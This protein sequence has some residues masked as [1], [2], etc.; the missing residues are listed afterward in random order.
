[1]IVKQLRT[2]ILNISQN[3][4]QKSGTVSHGGAKTALDEFVLSMVHIQVGYLFVFYIIIF[5]ISDYT[6]KSIKS[7]QKCLKK[8]TWIRIKF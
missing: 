5:K 7:V 2:D 6:N 1:L 8:S 3:R 4:G